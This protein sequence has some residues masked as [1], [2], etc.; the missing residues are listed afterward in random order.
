MGVTTIKKIL[1]HN[2]STSQTFESLSHGMMDHIVINHTLHRQ[3]PGCFEG[4][5]SHQLCKKYQIPSNKIVT[6]SIPIF[7]VCASLFCPSVNSHFYHPNYQTNNNQK[8]L[9]SLSA[10]PRVLPHKMHAS[11]C[12]LLIGDIASLVLRHCIAQLI[13]FEGSKD[14]NTRVEATSL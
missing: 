10:P 14:P 1:P 3:I 6:V 5:N 8:S 9:A 11:G 7:F 13:P 4:R 12:V 2:F